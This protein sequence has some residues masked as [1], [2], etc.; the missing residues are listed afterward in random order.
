M[1]KPVRVTYTGGID[2][3]AVLLPSGDHRTVKRGES[4][5]ILA[6]DAASLHPDDWTV[7]AA[8]KGDDK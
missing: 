8:P 6:T 5:E 7:N 1:S 4:I 2:E 3:V